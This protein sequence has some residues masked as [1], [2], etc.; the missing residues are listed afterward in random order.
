MIEVLYASGSE[1]VTPP[2]GIQV[3]VMKGS[4]WPVSDPV[5]KMRPDLFTTDV[6]YGL[7]YSEPPP[8]YD[9]DLEPIEVEE[10]TANPGEKRS[11][12]RS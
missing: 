12:R 9:S 6:R 5:V 10:A 1:W 2:S 7:S 4:R 8:G 11:A 3:Q